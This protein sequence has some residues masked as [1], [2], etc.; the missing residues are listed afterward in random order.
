MAWHRLKPTFW[1][2]SDRPRQRIY[3]AF[4]LSLL[5]H[6]LLLVTIYPILP[7]R[8]SWDRKPL[9]ATVIFRHTEHD[10]KEKETAPATTSVPQP[11]RSP[12]AQR[13]RIAVSGA[14]DHAVTNRH[15][16]SNAP[17][18][19]A[20]TSSRPAVLLSQMTDAA[21]SLPVSPA[22]DT[23]PA[24][25]SEDLR[26]YRMALAIQARRFNDYPM[27]ARQHGWQGRVEIASAFSR[28][29]I[30]T[31][32]SISRSSGHRVLDDQALRMIE[33]ASAITP[34]PES[35]RGRDFRLIIPIEFS[36]EE[37]R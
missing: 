8:P 9:P 28:Q 25:D 36:L 1:P 13:Q 34:L 21:S 23:T 27:A 29:P 30:P 37:N 11:H 19:P 18:S 24:V 16:K 10:I 5:V 22:E 17:A 26:H 2:I 14:E 6:A 31:Q 35:L 32:N 20:R 15:K 33:Q 4:L 3:R 7:I 12:S